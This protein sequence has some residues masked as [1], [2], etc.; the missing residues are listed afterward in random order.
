A[1]S[2]CA[3]VAPW[4]ER[5]CLT[6]IPRFAQCV[7]AMVISR[8]RIWRWSVTG[9]RRRWSGSTA[10]SCGCASRALTPTRCFAASSTT[11]EA[12]VSRSRPTRWSRPVSATSHTAVL[13]TELRTPTGLVAV[14][15]A[16]ALR[17]GTDL[18]DDAPAG[19]RELI[20]SAVV[21]DGFVRLRVELDP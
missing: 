4:Q 1:A 2:T 13:T 17:P 14:T 10:G 5:P 20:R 18:S 9:R 3:V 11:P 8:S 6:L 16:L 19:R 21:V 7:D 12:A 15:D